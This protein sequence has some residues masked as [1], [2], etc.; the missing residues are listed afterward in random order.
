M[1]RAVTPMLESYTVWARGANIWTNHLTSRTVQS[2]FYK[3]ISPRMVWESGRPE[4]IGRNSKCY[5]I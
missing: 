3:A 5:M 1:N 2:I 4:R